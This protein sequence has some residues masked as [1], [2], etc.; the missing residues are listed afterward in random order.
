MVNTLPVFFSEPFVLSRDNEDSA[1][2]KLPENFDFAAGTNAVPLTII[3]FELACRYYPI[4]FAA[5]EECSAM[6]VLGLEL[7]KNLFVNTQGAWLSSSYIPAYVRKFPFVFLQ[8]ENEEKYTLCI[9]ASYRSDE[10]SGLPVF[11]DDEPSQQ[12][13][14]ALE[15]CKK[16]QAAWDSTRELGEFLQKNDLLIERRADIEMQT[17]EKISLDGFSVIDREKFEE[18]YQQD[19]VLNDISPQ[20]MSAIHSHFVSMNNWQSLVD[21]NASII[22]P[23]IN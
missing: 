11:S 23:T 10:V 6:S 1:Y 21:L 22:D 20:H 3:E 12:I 19:N 2:V 15:F 14:V 5:G 18:M 9:E 7:G 17:G 8:S 16:F 4:V 13:T